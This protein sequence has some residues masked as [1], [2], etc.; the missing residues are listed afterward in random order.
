[1]MR[2]LFALPL[3]AMATPLA[4]QSVAPGAPVASAAK[5][6]SPE[7]ETKA[8]SLAKILNSEPII[9]GDATDDSKAKGM[10]KTLAQS[11]PELGEMERNYPGILDEIAT[12]I[13][14]IINKSMQQR[15]PELQRRQAALYAQNLDAA[16]LDYLIKFYTSSTGQKMIQIMLA[17]VKSEAMIA[18]ASSNPDSRVSGEAA[19]KDVQATVPAIMNAMTPEDKRALVEFSLSSALPKVQRM[20][21]QTQKNALTWMDESAPGEEGAIMEA[22][23]T[24]IE[25][26]AQAGTKK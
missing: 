2:A 15:L 23:T 5:S 12:A 9:I 22:M 25:K 21:L 19:L 4:A 20:A 26:Y 10:L 24:I 18:E 14:P 13:L 3:L 16:E 11:S 6:V 7:I 1:M 8:L 17:N